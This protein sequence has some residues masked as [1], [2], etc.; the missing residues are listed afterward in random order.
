VS[1]TLKEA[2]HSLISNIKRVFKENN[3]PQLPIDEDPIQ[4]D[5]SIICFPGAP[6]LK[7]SPEKIATIV[8][9]LVSDIALVKKVSVVKAFCNIDIDWDYLLLD[10]FKEISEKDYGRGFS[11]DESILVEHTSAN[12][13]GPFHMGRARNPI[14]GDSISRLL[15]Y[16][17]YDV[18]TEYY[19][20]DTGR[21][22]ATVA[23]GIKNF[24][25][26]NSEKQDHKLVECYRQ[27]SDALKSNEEIKNQI[28]QKM[29]LIESGNKEALAEVKNAA[30]MMLS[31]MRSSLKRLN[32]EADSYFHESDLILDNSV[33]EVIS[34]LKKSNIC[35]EEQGAFYLDLGNK[36]IAGRNQKFFFT[37]NNGLSLYTTRDIA[38][39][40][41]KF[42][43]FP[44]ALNILGEDH[45]LQSTLL[46]IALD[47]LESSKPDNLFY[48]FVNL[49]GGKMSTRA[50]RVVYL[51]DMMEK[52]VSASFERLKDVDMNLEQKNALAEKIGIGS[53]RYNILKVQPE[54]GFTFSIDDALSIQGDS[55]PFAMYSHARMC[56]IIKK[57]GRN[58]PKMNVEIGLKRPEIELIRI[59]AKWPQVV[60]LSATKLAI[61]KVPNYIHQLASQFNNFYRDCKV[62]GDANESLRINL[63]FSAKKI[64]FDALEIIGIAAPERM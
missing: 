32:A 30:E 45:K 52:I 1:Q 47:E 14:I 5:L 50:G 13:T 11:K 10:I 35:V 21:Q 19:V 16:N 28:Y 53:L 31:G 62:I 36:N 6:V 27:A 44:K 37:R 58:I 29:E 8:S 43:R 17:G 34:S 57:Y 38:Y 64:L 61:H 15:K 60:E 63:V 22:A 41:N 48:S 12:A 9:N 55:A 3:F 33:N 24:E 25:E 23:F 42:E 4:G 26:G 51:D 39:H 56:S 49:P 46:N 20:N 40:L 59:M 7:E 54:K 2:K 18:T